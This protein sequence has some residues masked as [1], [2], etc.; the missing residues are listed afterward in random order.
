MTSTSSSVSRTRSLSRSPSSVRG[1]CR[2]GVSTRTSWASGRCTMP[3]MVCRVVCGLLEVIA[4][5]WPTSA[6]VSVDLPAFGRP[7]RQANPARYAGSSPCAAPVAALAPC[8]TPVATCQ[9]LGLLGRRLQPAAT[10][11]VA[12]RWRRPAIRSAVRAARPP[13]ACDPGIGTRPSALAEQAADGV[14][15]LVLDLDVEQ[16]GRAR[17]CAGRRRPGCAPSPRSSTSGRLAVVLVGDL[18]DDLLDDV[19][20]RHQAGGAAVL[21]DDDRHVRLVALHLAQQVV[22]R[23]ALGHEVQRAHQLVDRRVGGL[24]GRRASRRATSLR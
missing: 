24:A 19:L 5:F 16:L 6:L 22:H 20:D 21:V 9:P 17:R 1:R 13:R 11:T 2:P 10:S 4:T 12:I 18:A 3:R 7:T 8:A 23:L 14:D 15:L